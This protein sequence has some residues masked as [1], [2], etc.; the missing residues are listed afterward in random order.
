[1]CLADRVRVCAVASVHGVMPP[2]SQ[3]ARL[4]RPCFVAPVRQCCSR[5]PLRTHCVDEQQGRGHMS[6]TYKCAG[7]SSSWLAESS[8]C[9]GGHGARAERGA[10]CKHQHGLSTCR[11]RCRRRH[12]RATSRSAATTGLVCRR[13]RSFKEQNDT[14]YRRAQSASAPVGTGGCP[15]DCRHECRHATNLKDAR[16]R[17]SRSEVQQVAA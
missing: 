7:Q 14:A 13:A 12:V 17:D 11:T 16:P 1:M 15:H 3:Q 9:D 4:K 2:A 6:R 5:S 8:R 10:P